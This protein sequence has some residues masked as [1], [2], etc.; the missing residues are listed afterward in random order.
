M[1]GQELLEEFGVE[2]VEGADGVDDGVLRRQLQH[3]GDVAELEVG[4]DEHD[5]LV[6]ALG[7][8]HR[9]V[10]GDDRLARPALGGEHRDD[11]A[12]LAVA[13]GQRRRPG[14]MP[15][16]PPRG[17]WPHAATAASNCA[18][19]TGAWSTSLTPARSARWSMSVDSSSVTMMAPTSRRAARS[20][21]A[22]TSSSLA[23]KDG[24]R[25]TTTGAP[26]SDDASSPI[27][28]KATVPFP[29]CMASRERVAWS[30]SMTATPIRG[31]PPPAA[32]D[33]GWG[34][35]SPG[36]PEKGRVTWCPAYSWL[37]LGP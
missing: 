1:C 9:E 33:P 20:C 31:A 17:R 28:P 22:E 24:P 3:H 18:V 6:A 37:P 16:G 32:A 34:R 13:E 21:S 27:E 11:P 5:R 7:Q 8:Q 4:V 26:V 25:T 23:A 36:S 30:S 2:A 35:P 19:S 10:G 29:S 12:E 14:S 15:P